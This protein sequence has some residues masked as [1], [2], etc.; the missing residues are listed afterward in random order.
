[1]KTDLM[2]KWKVFQKAEV[3]V[4]AMVLEMEAAETIGK[5]QIGTVFFT[6]YS[7]FLKSSFQLRLCSRHEICLLTIMTRCEVCK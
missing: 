6:F 4:L 7:G 3:G 2:V 5:T 1:M